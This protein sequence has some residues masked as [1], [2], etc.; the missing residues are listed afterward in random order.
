MKSSVWGNLRAQ[1]AAWGGGDSG[2]GKGQKTAEHPGRLWDSH[3]T[4][5]R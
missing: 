4:F 2:T 5:L 1:E 3:L